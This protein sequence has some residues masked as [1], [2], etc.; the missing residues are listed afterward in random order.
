MSFMKK[1]LASVGIGATKVDAQLEQS[2]VQ[3][4]GL[5]SGKL[6]IS[7]GNVAQDIDQIYLAIM[8]TY[9]KESDDNKITKEAVIGKFQISE[10]FVI[11]PNE[12]KEIPFQFTVP[13]DTPITVGNAKV[14]VQTGLDVKNAVDPSDRD[15]LKVKPH[16]LAENVLTALNELGFTLRKAKSEE[17]PYH[18]RKRLPFVQELEFYPIGEPFRG[19]LDELE[20][21]FFMDDD[22]CELFLEIDRKARGLGGFLAEA[23]DID[24]SHVRMMV[25]NDNVSSLKQQ[26]E[27]VI[28]QNS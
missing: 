26:L 3:P 15:Y 19:K 6:L 28:E 11:Q 8:T 7:G 4:G 27:S 10:K 13:V 14:W 12:K 17:A 9:E 23:L 18:L 21:V 25:T 20:V 24:E 22:K 2:E 5:L 1:V 16:P